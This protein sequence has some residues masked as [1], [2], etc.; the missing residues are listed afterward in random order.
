MCAGKTYIERVHP[1]DIDRVCVDKTH[2]ERVCA[3]GQAHI[4]RSHCSS[5]HIGCVDRW[6]RYGVLEG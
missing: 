4:V 5:N 1:I 2:I 3:A 6:S